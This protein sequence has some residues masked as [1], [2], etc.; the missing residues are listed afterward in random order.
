MDNKQEAVRIEE[1]DA[2]SAV[3]KGSAR[4]VL[5]IGLLLAVIALS[6][7]WITGSLS[8]GEVEERATVS[9]TEQAREDRD[10]E[11]DVLIPEIE[12]GSVDG[13]ENPAE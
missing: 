13:A 8:Q 10:V 11:S 4:R 1:V 12:D 5:T 2:K 9:G 7:I 6:A 3:R